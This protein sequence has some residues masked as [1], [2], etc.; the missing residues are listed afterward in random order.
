MR[1]FSCLNC[2][3][4]LSIYVFSGER[5]K[6]LAGRLNPENKI[7]VCREKKIFA[8]FAVGVLLVWIFRVYVGFEDLGEREILGNFCLMGVCWSNRIKAESPSNTGI[9]NIFLETKQVSCWFYLRNYW[10][11]FF[12]NV[13]F[14]FDQMGFLVFEVILYVFGWYLLNVF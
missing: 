14:L 2:G 8:Y 1:Y 9:F 11:L 3:W 7:S 12:L 6:N 13:F 5:G 10:T 4:V